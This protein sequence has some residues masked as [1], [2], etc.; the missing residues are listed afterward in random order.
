MPAL[1]WTENGKW[2]CPM[3]GLACAGDWL[4][5]PA[6]DYERSPDEKP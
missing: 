4:V 6:C 3:C 1:E 2:I 5:C